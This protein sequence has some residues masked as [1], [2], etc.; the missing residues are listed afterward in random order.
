MTDHLPFTTTPL[1]VKLR[2]EDFLRLDE[3]GAF[4]DYGKT[5]LIRGE[6]FYMN[7]QH[8]PHARMKLAV[9]DALRNWISANDANFDVLVEATVSMPPYSAP[10]PDLV[11]TSEPDGEGPV[12]VS[13]VRLVIE[14]AD[15]TLA[16]DLG[17]KAS[18]YAENAVPEYWVVDVKAGQVHQ[19]WAPEA[20]A[21]AQVRETPLAD[22]VALTIPGLTVRLP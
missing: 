15:T 19:H 10:E 2:V 22:L 1:P 13:S 4:N 18:V 14:I 16:N 12:P 20:G 6:V 8:R 7:S 3:A 11:I 9:Y 21:Y 17:V 5:E